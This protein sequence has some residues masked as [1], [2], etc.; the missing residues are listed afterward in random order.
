MPRENLLRWIRNRQTTFMYNSWHVPGG[1][2]TLVERWV[3]GCAAQIGC[4]FSLSGLL[5]APFL[6]EN[7]FRYR[8][9]FWKM[10]NFR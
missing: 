6:F 1:G 7:W 5:M 2:G 4:L 3:Q 10:H 8:S 9:R